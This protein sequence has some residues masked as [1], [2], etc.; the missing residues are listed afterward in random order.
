MRILVFHTVIQ[1][2]IKLKMNLFVRNPKS[3]LL[4]K[5]EMLNS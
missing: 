3:L 4:Q 2:I 1:Q 5:S